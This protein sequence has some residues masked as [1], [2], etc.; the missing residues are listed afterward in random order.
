MSLIR[1][2]DFSPVKS[3]LS[4]ERLRLREL[5]L[6]DAPFI[7]ELLNSPEWLRFIGNKKIKTVEDAKNYLKKGPLKSYLDNGYGL[8]LVEAK[9]DSRSIGMCGIINREAL[10]HPDIGF[11]FLPQFYNRG[12]AFEIAG[13]TLNYGREKL[14]IKKVCAITIPENLRSIRLLEKLGLQFQKTICLPGSEE[15]LQLYSN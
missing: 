11:A 1:Q 14:N 15:L 8:Y 2:P 5:N 6:S 9:E 7:I 4:T 12:Y 10:D 13:A 3:I